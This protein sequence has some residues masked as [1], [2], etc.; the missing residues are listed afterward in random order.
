MKTLHTFV[1][2]ALLVV[3]IAP[4]HAQSR[5]WRMANE[6]GGQIILTDRACPAAG[7]DLLR[8]VY[9]YSANGQRQT[10]CWALFDDLVQI[11]W[12]AGQRSVF[13][14]GDF[15]ASPANPPARPAGKSSSL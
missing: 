1:L 7:S 5:S 3:S 6:A 4:A 11:K 14:P 2:A 13:N 15:T 12:S 8:E 9:A 10:G